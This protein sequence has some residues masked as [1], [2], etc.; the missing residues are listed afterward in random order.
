MG[1]DVVQANY[2]ELDDIANQFKRQAEAN[3]ELHSRLQNSFQPLQH[4]EWIGLGADAFFDEMTGEVFPAMER[5]TSALKNAGSV[6]LEIKNIIQLAEEEAGAPFQNGAGGG[7]PSGTGQASLPD[8]VT[9]PPGTFDNRRNPYSVGSPQE[10]TD[11]PFQSGPADALR[12]NVDVGGQTIPVYVPK[13]PGAAQG[14][15]HSVDEIAKGLAALP[16]TSRALV[17]QVNMDPSQ[18]PDDAFWAQEYNRPNFRSYMTAGSDGVVDIY[19]LPSKNS[20]DYLDGTMIHETGHIWSQQNWGSETD[21][22]WND[23]KGAMSRDSGMTSEYAKA[24]L[25]EDFSETL[26][27]Y[28]Q[29][30]G[31]P[32]EAEFR[33]TMPNRFRIIDEIET[34]RR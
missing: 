21:A 33:R 1:N 25:G 3:A 8:V 13:T 22:R 27:Q 4:G 28:H 6:T 14:Q 31:T 29:V 24:S 16:E 15:S 30:K 9:T 23:W 18:N 20:Q 17:N 19:S 32:Q 34:G 2:E 5:L 7:P 26:Q 11:H 10:V 12:Y